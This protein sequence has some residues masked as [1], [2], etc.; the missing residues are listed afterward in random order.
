MTIGR[1]QRGDPLHICRG[2]RYGVPHQVVVHYGPT[3]P[4]CERQARVDSLLRELGSHCA[5]C[6]KILPRE[7]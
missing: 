1:P 7:H 5:N 2:L 3:C 6:K 4:V